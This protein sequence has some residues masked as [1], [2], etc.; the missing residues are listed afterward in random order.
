MMLD[1][2]AEGDV[3]CHDTVREIL[4]RKGKRVWSI[5]PD[6]TVFDAVL[7]MDQAGAGALMVLSGGRVVGVISER[8]YA[9]KVILRGRSSK[10]TRVSEI[11]TSPVVSV[12]LEDRAIDCLRLM[13][14]RRVRHLPVVELGELVGVV[15]IGDLVNAVLS[16]Q[17]AEVRSLRSYVAGHYPG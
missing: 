13:T 5:G 9:R 16:A 10:D 1:H 14:E 17:A 3:S 11:M 12:S 15:S 2:F 8:D 4:N 6:A 7:L